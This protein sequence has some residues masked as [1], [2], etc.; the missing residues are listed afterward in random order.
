[1]NVIIFFSSI[2][3][4]H[5]LFEQYWTRRSICGSLNRRKITT[6]EPASKTPSIFRVY[7]FGSKFNL[8]NLDSLIVHWPWF[9]SQLSLCLYRVGRAPGRHCMVIA[10]RLLDSE[11]DV[12]LALYSAALVS[13][14]LGSLL[15]SFIS[16]PVAK[17]ISAFS[18]RVN[19]IEIA[20]RFLQILARSFFF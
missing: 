10:R 7:D 17:L 15:L 14:R 5:S 1:M 3:L 12:A 2:N 18:R 20:V 9:Y 16:L 13:C 19:I 11:A 8:H 6:G 4:L